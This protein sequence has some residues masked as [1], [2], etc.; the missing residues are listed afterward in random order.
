MSILIHNSSL[1]SERI[2]GGDF[3]PFV[4]L[5]I[6]L[7]S[8]NLTKKGGSVKLIVTTPNSQHNRLSND[9]RLVVGCQVEF[10]DEVFFLMISFDPEL[11]KKFGLHESI[12]FERIRILHIKNEENMQNYYQ[13]RFWVDLN[14]HIY[15]KFLYYISQADVDFALENLVKLNVLDELK[16]PELFLYTLNEKFVEKFKRHLN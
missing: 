14:N 2:C 10:N 5:S 11:A 6:Q 15:S 9:K 16:L 12:I 7:Y 3:N 13:N 8:N 4:L 1:I